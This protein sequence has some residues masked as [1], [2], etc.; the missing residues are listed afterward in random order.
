MIQGKGWSSVREELC[1]STCEALGLSANMGRGAGEKK[2]YLALGDSHRGKGEEMKV[3]KSQ[4]I[5][6]GKDTQRKGVSA[7][8]KLHLN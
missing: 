3:K 6:F 4:I 1:F 5:G 7:Q 2:F 8:R